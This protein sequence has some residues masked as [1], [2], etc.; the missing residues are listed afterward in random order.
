MAVRS[1]PREIGHASL[2]TLVRVPVN[3]M[4]SPS[5]SYSRRVSTWL[6]ISRLML[7]REVDAANVSPPAAGAATPD[8]A[9]RV[10][11]G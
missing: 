5:L 8:E 4:P 11:D 10:S 2:D 6:T 7:I 3:A 1:T 9:V